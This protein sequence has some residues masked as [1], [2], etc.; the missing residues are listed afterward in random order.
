MIGDNGSF[1]AVSSHSETDDGGV[2]CCAV[3]IDS[4]CDEVEVI[5]FMVTESGSLSAVSSHSETD[6]GGVVC[7]VVV[8]DSSCDEVEVITFM[9][10]ES[11]SLSAVS[12]HSETDDGGVV[13]CVVVI[14][15]SCD[16]VE[17]I[18]FI[19]VEEEGFIVLL[20]E[21]VRMTFMVEEGTSVDVIEMEGQITVAESKRSRTNNT[22]STCDYI[23]CILFQFVVKNRKNN[24]NNL[25]CSIVTRI[26]MSKYDYSSHSFHYSNL[27]ED[28]FNIGAAFVE[29]I[30][31]PREP[32]EMRLFVFKLIDV[33][34]RYHTMFLS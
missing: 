21:L 31:V 34:T 6:D 29:L 26:C 7:C 13:C 19:V 33:S 25:F 12:S 27:L 10:T 30:K 3:I 16:E 11:G 4:S 18:T 32:T 22:Y 28:I 17:V 2:V 5:T 8:I 23:L 15:S 20:T 1:S 9:V 14:D 24:S